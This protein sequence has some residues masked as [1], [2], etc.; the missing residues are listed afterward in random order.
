MGSDMELLQKTQS[1]GQVRLETDAL[2]VINYAL[3]RNGV[4]PIRSVTIENG[5]NGVLENLELTITAQPEFA[6]PVTRHIELL[7]PG[8]RLTIAAPAPEIDGGYL[9]TLTE[10]ISGRFQ[11]RLEKEGE[12]LASEDVQTTVLAF[13]QWHGIHNYPELLASFVTPNHPQLAQ[14]IARATEYL[15]KWTGDTSMDG[16]QSRDPNRVLSQ[17]GAI[18][19][20]LKE[21]AIA[22]AVP[23]AS[24]QQSGQR[25]RL[26][27]VVLQQKL[28]TCLDLSLLYA[29]CLEAVGLHPLLIVTAGHIFVGLWLEERM[30]PECIQDDGSL[31][32]K[33]LAS[34][35]NE[36]AVVETTMVTTGADSSF[37]EAR[38][39]AGGHFIK[40]PLECIIDVRRARMSNV[41][42]LP[43]RVS[44]AGGWK[45]EHDA[46]FRADHLA[47]PRKLDETIVVD[48]HTAETALP[49]KVQWERKLLDLGMRNTLINL[50]LTKTQLPILTNSLDQLENALASGS[51]FHILPRPADWTSGEFSFEKLHELGTQGIIQAEFDN[52]R[53]RCAYTQTELMNNIK[54]LYRTART[55]LEENGANT[56]YLALGIL[57]WYESPRSTKARYAPIILLPIE[58]VRRSAAQGYVIRLRDEEPQMNVTL[59]E[60]LKQD[61]GI[62]VRGVDPLPMDEQGIDIRRV[63]TIVRQA[64]MGQPHWDVLETA[65]IGIFSFSQFVMWNDIRNRAED[66]MR[67]KVVSSLMEGKLTWQAQPLAMGK[68]VSEE[69][70]LQPM[71]ADASQ[72]YAIEA[73]C[74]GESFVLHGPPGTGKSQ[75]ITSLIANALAKGKRVLFVA[76]KMAALSVVQK[77][78]ESIGI[79]PF[80]LEL[81]SNKSRKKDVLEQLRRA[82]EVTRTTTASE[83]AAKAEQLSSLR[84]Q[85]DDYAHALHEPLPCGYDLYELINEYERCRDA[86]EIS[87]FNPALLESLTREVLD[88][89]RMLLERLVAAGREVGHPY[90]HPLS[91]V[92]CSEYAQ[93]L[94]TAVSAAVDDYGHALEQVSQLGARL[95][96]LLP[97]QQLTLTDLEWLVQLAKP[98]LCWYQM[99]P[100]WTKVTFPQNYFRE[101]S[102]L[103]QHSLRA[104]ELEQQLLQAF[105]PEVL[106]LDAR[107]LHQEYMEN[108]TKWFLPKMFGTNR[109]VK[110]LNLMAK[111]PIDKEVLQG[112]INA[113]LDRQQEQQ[114]AQALLSRYGADLG[115]WYAGSATDWSRVDQLAQTAL[116]CTE[117]LSRITGSD[118]FLGSYCGKPELKSSLEQIGSS[119]QRYL[120]TRQQLYDLLKIL[121]GENTLEA[122]QQLCCGIRENSEQLREW[123]A[124]VAT[125]EEAADLGLGNAVRA[126]ADGMDHDDLLLAARKAVLQGL[127]SLAIDADPALN[128]FSG[129]VFHKKIEQYKQLDAQWTQLSRQEIYCR[130]AARVPDFTREAANSSELGILQRCIRSGGRGTSIRRLFDQIPNLLPRLS[131]CMLMSPISAAQYLDPKAEPFDIVVFDEASQLP[132][133]KAVGV[134]ARG[135]EAVIVGDPKQMPP[136]SFFATNTVDEDNLEA[137]D[138]ES[139]LD[140]C[141]A[142]NMPQSHLLWHYRSRHESLIA[143]S[144]SRFYEN[145]LYTFPSVND[146]A[147]KVRLIEVEGVFER[148]KFRVNRAEAQAVV[149]E[150]KRRCHDAVLSKQ[151]VGVV[152]FN[153]SQQNLIDDLLSEACMQDQELEKWAYGCEEPVFIKNLENVQGDE[154]DVILFS[155]GYGPDENGKVSMNFGPLNRDGGWRRLNV[156]V[157]RARCE[158]MVFST[159]RPDQINLNRTGAEGVAALR[160]FL[161]YAQ[162]R[163]AALEQTTNQQPGTDAVAAA[164]CDFLESKGYDTDRCVGRSQ[165]RLDIGVIDPENKEQ[166]LLGILLDGDGYGSA[167]TT[168]DREI[169]QTG[170]LRG[171]GWSIL[172]VFTM[173]WWDNREKECKRILKTLQD[174]KKSGRSI[175]PQL[176]APAPAPLQVKQ[177]P[178]V[179][180]VEEVYQAVQLP[181]TP[182]TAEEFILPGNT[183]E[184][185]KR[186]NQVLKTEAPVSASQLQKRVLQSYGITRS[187]SRIQAHYQSVLASMKLPSTLQTDGEFYWRGDQSPETYTGYRADGEGHAHR[188]LREIPVQELSN[189]VQAVLREQISMNHEDLLRETA[190]KLGYTR[191]GTTGTTAL[192]L[193]LVYAESQGRILCSGE[194]YKLP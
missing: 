111:A 153:I 17:A 189:G 100:A 170:V 119:H 3:E 83:F 142:L 188:E 31:I 110:Q 174:L 193:A 26:C 134:L 75:T 179:T 34:G 55:A 158:M 182:L 10:Q 156:A 46:S 183:R 102:Q 136:T 192:E 79:G 1:T 54:G 175:A 147:S 86:R 51:D 173:D 99:P 66:L 180:P 27:D 132:T 87:P 106:T 115:Q 105:R 6:R 117:E 165:Y 49:K 135:T 176:P 21:Q 62:T 97:A 161:E 69:D 37:D 45:V 32:T 113:L 42:P 88:Q 159:L 81:H 24:F 53:L 140:D 58:M 33:R 124:Y 72:L 16:Y 118:A 47:A 149:E 112:Y 23:P 78:L 166:Y 133:C 15:G 162:G 146:R 129:A 18:F 30:F 44:T 94:R 67:N 68:R 144:N 73:A 36:M 93:S 71:P 56:L 177:T 125:T 128:R 141:L 63:L 80:C 184:I 28:G 2:P 82:T 70:V 41:L 13:D 126:Y 143:F 186:I 160:G 139:I 103:A 164:I 114:A 120:Q 154:R 89:Q 155:I 152:T 74:S 172:R 4:A 168:R 90:G 8:Q 22:Y 109:L 171:L 116:S 50:R 190:K 12:V 84:H 122:E 185:K 138:L 98:M 91:R 169:A 104:T 43:H 57:R 92:R 29:S 137:E 167:R 150:L 96:P 151:S 194:M 77:R 131:P 108:A 20:A 85:L 5:T 76:E 39:T 157:S 61:F 59:L 121:P 14:I 145:K 191:L 148:G 107:Q 19:T 40:Q 95:L 52:K 25:V 123:I 163:A 181:L 178:A 9:A 64:V 130:L 187:G 48:Q 127:I 38:E 60:K 35:V 7:N 65:S 11:L 101:V